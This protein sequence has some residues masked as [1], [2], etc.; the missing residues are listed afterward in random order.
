M[1]SKITIELEPAQLEQAIN[2]LDAESQLRLA[3]QLATR[4]MRLV[5]AKLR[6]TVKRK[7]L[8]ARAIDRIVEQARQ[9]LGHRS[10]H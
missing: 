1:M 8:S 9:E 6:H 4:Q 2:R 3:K 10:P 5:V 7:H